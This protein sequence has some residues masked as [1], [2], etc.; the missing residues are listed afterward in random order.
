LVGSTKKLTTEKTHAPLV[1]QSRVRAAPSVVFDSFFGE[2]GRW[3]CREAEI[4]PKVGGTLRLCWPDG[5][6][7]GSFV[8][9]EPPSAARFSWHMQGD[10]LPPTMVVISMVPVGRDETALE[11]EHYGFGVGPEWDMLY[12]GAARAWA[13]YLKNLRA[14]LEAGVDLRED[15]E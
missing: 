10:A 7:E 2:P 1:F 6:C 5:C 3:L 4:D 11:V 9:F 13:A 15:D 14:V 12:V 8:Q